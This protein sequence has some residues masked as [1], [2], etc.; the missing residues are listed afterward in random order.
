VLRLRYGKFL[1]EEFED[2][3]GEIAGQEKIVES[4]HFAGDG[5]DHADE[6]Q[7]LEALC[8]PTTSR[9]KRR[10]WSRP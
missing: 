6:M 2:M 5:H 9:K 7:G 8:T 4:G 3:I 10:S 1:G